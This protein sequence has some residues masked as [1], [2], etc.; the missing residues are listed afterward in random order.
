MA[1]MLF[2][3][4]EA[5]GHGD[6]GIHGIVLAMEEL[7][8]LQLPTAATEFKLP[9]ATKAAPEP[10]KPMHRAL[11]LSAG[12]STVST[13]VMLEAQKN[14]LDHDGS[15]MGFMEM[16]HR[17]AGG[18][19]QNAMT[20]CT[21]ATRDLLDV[22]DDYHVLWM[23][24]GAHAQFAASIQNLV[25]PEGAI[26]VVRTG[27]WADRFRTTEAERL[28]KDVGVAWN[29]M[30]EN[31]SR[32]GAA[33]EWKWSENS[34][35]IHLCLNE[36]IQGCEYL[37]DP[38]LAD[39]APIISCD[40]T[41]TL[42]SRPMDIENYGLVYAS[43]G[44]NLGP[45]G[46]TCVI[47]R[48]DLLGKA[49]TEC[50]GVIN[51]SRQAETM[52]IQ[53]LYNTPPTYNFYMNSL[54]FKEYADMGGLEVIEQRAI[55]RA[56]SIYDM[57]DNSGGMYVNNVQ[58]EAR[59]RMNVPFRIVDRF[60][61]PDSVLEAKFIA[62]AEVKGIQQLF[63]HPLFPGL[64]VTMYNALPQEHV[65]ITAE[66]MHEFFHNYNE[67]RMAEP[68]TSAQHNARATTQTSTPLV[69]FA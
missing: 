28:C 1:H 45:A 37:Y 46:V 40:A 65:A 29:G 24:G 58:S 67:S 4:L 27:F 23:A 16:S 6:K 36:T 54:V 59:S 41:S 5:Q 63:A 14:F 69:G 43:A 7:N 57:I 56:A 25:S 26:D 13:D 33:D 62:E 66:F 64:R 49:R 61:T 38:K 52:P 9:E 30:N 21:D 17:D 34:E 12:P 20:Y 18:V 31:Y 32:V 48:D 51:Y 60:G 53:S 15:G 2:C 47:V 22:P 39:N 55:Q 44:K 42:L 19:V 3:S 8:K 11:N 68:T 35:M 50:P 10:K